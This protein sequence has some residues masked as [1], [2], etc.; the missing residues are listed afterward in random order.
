M[1][2]VRYNSIRKKFIADVRDIIGNIGGQISDAISKWAGSQYAAA[3]RGEHQQKSA[4]AKE[5]ALEQIAEIFCGPK[6]LKY[7]RV[8]EVRASL[9]REVCNA[10]AETLNS[11]QTLARKWGFCVQFFDWCVEADWIR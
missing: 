5:L 3:H 2:K 7:R 1:A 10:F 6:K 9:M 8:G 4:R 11:Q